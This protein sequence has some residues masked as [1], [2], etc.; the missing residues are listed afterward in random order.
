MK[1][2]VIVKLGGS[3]LTN[4]KKAHSLKE[5]H[6]RKIAREIRKTLNSD[7]HLVLG[8]GAGSYGHIAAKKYNAQQ[9]IHP[10]SGWEAYYLIRQDMIRMNLKLLELFADENLHPVTIQPSAILM[11]SNGKID[12]IKMDTITA[13]L[14]FNQIPLIHGDIILDKKQ[15]FTI[16]STEEQI[17]LLHKH[18][19]FDRII[20]ISDVDGVLDDNGEIIPIIN[21]Q[22]Y[23]DILK[24]LSGSAGEDVTGGM[25]SK[26]EEI[27]A[28]IKNTPKSEAHI[29]S[30]YS[31][32]GLISKAI[33]GE[34]NIGTKISI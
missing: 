34:A 29:I 3:F 26:V 33:L 2:K 5:N 11:A 1:S 25:R 6:V 21:S 27:F 9:G 22:N 31:K 4:K 14:N 24:H 20:L 28:L 32:E 23:S 12:S 8:H 30:G 19:Q 10:Q 13:L 17:S 16:A 18:L 7:I 15:G